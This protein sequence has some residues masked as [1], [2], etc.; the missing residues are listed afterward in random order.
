MLYTTE[1]EEFRSALVEFIRAEK[2][3]EEARAIYDNKKQ[4][5][6][7]IALL[8]FKEFGSFEFFSDVEVQNFAELAILAE[9]V[10]HNL[11]VGDVVG[12]IY[13]NA[14]VNKLLGEKIISLSKLRDA[15]EIFNIDSKKMYFAVSSQLD[16]YSL[17][18]AIK[19][20]EVAKSYVINRITKKNSLKSDEIEEVFCIDN[21]SDS[22]IELIDSSKLLDKT[23]A[24]EVV[25]YKNST[26]N[27]EDTKK[28][29]LK[30][31][32]LLKKYLLLKAFEAYGATNKAFS[33]TLDYVKTRKQFGVAIGSFQAVQHQLAD[34]YLLLEQ[35]RG[36][37]T[38]TLKNIE[39]ENVYSDPKQTAFELDSSVMFALKNCSKIIETAIQLHGGIGF[40]WEYDLHFYL[41][42]VKFI[43]GLFGEMVEVEDVL[44]N[45]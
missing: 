14:Y 45:A 34:S 15:N 23:Q 35:I 3:A 25:S 22:N 1:Q 41:R 36:L 17:V 28:F 9:E 20:Q 5:A 12:E 27:S 44:K 33:M 6:D 38:F 42:R 21:D 32:F 16:F 29:K 26:H 37:L 18:V 10:G 31:F 39:K 11:I 43:E 40:T 13:W 2:L 24:I 7:S 8:K 4:F 19:K 30:N